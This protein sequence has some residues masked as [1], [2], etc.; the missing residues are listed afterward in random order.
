MTR[1]QSDRYDCVSCGAC[2][3][4]PDENRAEGYLWYLEVRDTPLLDKPDLRKKLVVLDPDGVPHLRL[5]KE[6]GRCVALRGKLGVRA[7]C[8]IYAL[9][10]KGCRLLQPGDPRCVLARKERGLEP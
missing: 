9:R 8:S 6:T 1:T 3:V 4:N 7:T 10:P 5:E 2:C